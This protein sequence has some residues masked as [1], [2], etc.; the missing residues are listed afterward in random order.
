MATAAG[1]E[2]ILFGGIARRK[3]VDLVSRGS[4]GGAGGTAINAG[5]THRE[6]ELAVGIHIAALHGL[7]ALLIGIDCFHLST[8]YAGIVNETIRFLRSKLARKMRVS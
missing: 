7:P 2:S 4:A 1:A 3:E 6:D 5:G 8:R